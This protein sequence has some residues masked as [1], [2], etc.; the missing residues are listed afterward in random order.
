MGVVGVE[1][2]GQ[3]SHLL[4]TCSNHQVRVEVDQTRAPRLSSGE[5]EERADLVTKTRDGLSQATRMPLLQK[6]GQNDLRYQFVE[7]F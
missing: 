5:T 3:M 4:W 2:A 7:K 6:R 1:Q